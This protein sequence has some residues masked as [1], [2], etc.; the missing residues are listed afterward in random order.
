[1]TT[2]STILKYKLGGIAGTIGQNPYKKKAKFEDIGGFRYQDKLNQLTT[3][4]FGV[5]NNEFTKS[6]AFLERKAYFPLLQPYSG[7]VWDVAEDTKEISLQTKEL[8][9]HLT[10]RV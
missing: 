9:V 3:L 7:L 2:L 10:R 4:D 1:L 6:N 5:P 8:A